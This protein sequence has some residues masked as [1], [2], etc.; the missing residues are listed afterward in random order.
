MKFIENQGM[1]IGIEIFLGLCHVRLV[2]MLGVLIFACT[3]FREFRESWS[4]SQKL[5]TRKISF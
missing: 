2:C 4:I 5:N 3:N 1:L